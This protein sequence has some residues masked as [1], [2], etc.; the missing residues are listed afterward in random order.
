M[1]HITRPDK[2]TL[3]VKDFFCVGMLSR[4]DGAPHASFATERH[5]LS[6]DLLSFI[7]R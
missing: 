4:P 1:H 2:T 3:H 6:E 5:R 7:R